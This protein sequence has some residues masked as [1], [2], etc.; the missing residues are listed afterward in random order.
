MWTNGGVSRSEGLEC[1]FP[2]AAVPLAGST[3]P[4]HPRVPVT[5]P[6]CRTRAGKDCADDDVADGESRAGRRARARRR[7]PGQRAPVA[8]PAPLPAGRA[9]RPDSAG[10]VGGRAGRAGIRRSA[11]VAG[12]GR[13]RRGGPLHPHPHPCHPGAGGAASRRRRA[14]GEAAGP[15]HGRVRAS[16]AGLRADGPGLPGRLPEPG[17]GGRG[18]TAPRRQHRR[19]RRDPVDRRRGRLDP[20]G[21]LLH[22]VPL[23]GSPRTRRGAGDGRCADQPVRPRGRHRAARRR[24]GAGPGRAVRRAGPVP[25]QRHPH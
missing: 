9:G 18:R 3:E 8:G 1:D 21:V 14:A 23:G 15:D 20:A 4:E 13:R 6:R 7:A 5:T 24:L 2:L 19:A 17:F 10:A 22:Q 25:R 12:R 16:A 11:G